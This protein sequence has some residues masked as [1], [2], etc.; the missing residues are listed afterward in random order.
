M[1]QGIYSLTGVEAKQ[2]SRVKYTSSSHDV[3]LKNAKTPTGKKRFMVLT[4][5]FKN[6][7]IKS[8]RKNYLIVN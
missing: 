3:S 4:N 8:I 5:N 1:R 7:I 2:I 6:V